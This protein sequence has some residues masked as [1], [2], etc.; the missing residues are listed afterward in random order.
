MAYET[1]NLGLTLVIPTTGQIQWGPTIKNSTWKK[2]SQHKHEGG[3]DGNQIQSAGIASEAVTTAKLAK[4]IAFTQAATLT[5]AG[6]T[7]TIDFNNGNKQVLD[8]GSASGD[9]AVT[10]S[11]PQSGATY[12]I[13]IIQGVTVRSI[14]WPASVLFPGGIN[15]TVH[16]N[17]STVNLVYLDYDGTNYLALFENELA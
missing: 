3:G 17:A 6:T 10:L 12:R 2:I 4:N 11:N 5:P 9:V 1:I 16:H 13:K 14:T 15:P 7:Q 8:L